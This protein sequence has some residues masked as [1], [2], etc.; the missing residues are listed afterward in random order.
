MTQTNNNLERFNS[1]LTSVTSEEQTLLATGRSLLLRLAVDQ[2]QKAVDGNL[3]L[4]A[5]DLGQYIKLIDS[6]GGFY[7]VGEEAVLEKQRLAAIENNN[8]NSL[9]EVLARK[10]KH[11]RI[12]QQESL[13][14]STEQDNYI[15]AAVAKGQTDFTP[16]QAA[17]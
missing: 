5:A 4:K 17:D 8:A 10:Q 2:L 15:K 14:S 7:N 11:S 12:S 16:L 1:S 6:H 13:Q 9:R 3:E